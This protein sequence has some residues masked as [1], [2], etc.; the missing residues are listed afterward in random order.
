MRERKEATVR[1]V[2]NIEPVKQHHSKS[3]KGIL[4]GKIALENLSW[5]IRANQR[6]ERSGQKESR[7]RDENGNEIATESLPA[8]AK[9]V[10]VAEQCPVRSP[11]MSL[12]TRELAV[13]SH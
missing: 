10:A 13:I 6:K 12:G 9:H 2:E 11:L 8:P 7:T 5:Q 4:S 3:G 1:Q